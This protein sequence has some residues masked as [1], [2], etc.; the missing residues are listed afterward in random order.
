MIQKKGCKTYKEIIL[1]DLQKLQTNVLVEQS[2]SFVKNDWNNNL[3]I[4]G[5]DH[6]TVIVWSSYHY[7]T[8]I[9]Y[10][11]SWT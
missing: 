2:A 3:Q 5:D 10:C 9:L 4:A 8:S 7:M 11:L 1:N 6:Y